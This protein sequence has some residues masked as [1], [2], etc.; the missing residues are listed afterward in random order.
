MSAVA[1]KPSL[2]E[3]SLAAGQLVVFEHNGSPVLACVLGPKKNKYALLSMRA[4]ELELEASRLCTIAGSLPAGLSTLAEK[5]NFLEHMYNEALKASQEVPLDVVWS[6]LDGASNELSSSALATLYFGKPTTHQQLAMRLALL[7]DKT[8]FR[9]SADGFQPRNAT[10]VTELQRAQTAA[11]AKQ[12]RRAQF[13]VWLADGLRGNQQALQEDFHDLL[14]LLEDGAVEATHLDNQQQR[15]LRE[16]IESVAQQVLNDALCHASQT[17]R[18]LRERFIAVQN[19]EQ[20][21]FM[22]LEAIGHFTPSTN[23]AF[24]RHRPPLG[25]AKKASAQA[26]LL[27]QPQSYADLSA[28]E[29]AYRQDLTR[30]E[31]VTVDD[32]S[33]KDM[34]DALS[35][36]QVNGGYRLG[37]HI[38]DVASMIAVGS[39]LEAEA[40]LRATSIYCP[41]RTLH[42]LPEVLS[43]DRLSLV[44]GQ[45]R[46]ALS[47]FFVTDASFRI[48]ERSICMSLVRVGE[49][50]T[51]DQL[52]V[53]LEQGDPQMNLLYQIC[54]THEEE[55]NRN[56]A[57]RVSKR[58]ALAVLRDTQEFE[59]MEID[60]QDP[61]RNLVAETAVLANAYVASFAAE[62]RLPMVFRGQE[63]PAAEFATSQDLPAGPAQDYRQRSRLKKSVIDYRPVPHASLGLKAYLQV[64]SPIRR[65]VDIC[66]QRQLLHFLLHGKGFYS[67]DA[68]AQEVAIVEEPLS[69]ALQ[70][71]RETKRFWMLRFIE[72]LAQQGKTITGTVIRVDMKNPLVELD[73]VYISVPVR[74]AG[75]AQLGQTIEFRISAIDPRRDYLRLEPLGLPQN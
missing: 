72:R 30:L 53:R 34:D 39:A 21:A 15:E 11:L 6:S 33:T 45:A 67:A 38:S 55:R 12:E 9:R 3:S 41:D 54:T 73:Q 71:T 20:R 50:L 24:V 19:K 65:Y 10:T 23:L 43:E 64:T 1:P 32:I 70:I 4:K 27:Q 68:L 22:L 17:A 25:F 48:V 18:S 29:R 56:G 46:R 16:L 60:E 47:L 37:V 26:S 5:A 35:I 7:N 69:R 74:L 13:L 40:R 59:L 51:Y 31:M 52:G 58:E 62:R 42:M 61:A 63:Q 66:N 28:E 75:K 8:F 2:A 36:E 57:H 44:A 49:R 14:R